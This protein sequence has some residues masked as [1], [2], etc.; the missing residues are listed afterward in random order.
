M[1]RTRLVLGLTTIVALIVAMPAF[2]G[3]D[4]IGAAGKALGIAKKADK[5]SKVAKRNSRLALEKAGPGP[6]GPIG[7]EGP[8]GPAG[9][10]GQVGPQGPGGLTGLELV[11]NSSVHN[12]DSAKHV[13]VDCPPGKVAVGGG[14]DIDGGKSGGFPDVES[15]V[16]LDR[17]S[18][19]PSFETFQASA[20]ETDLVAH[21]WHLDVY[22]SCADGAA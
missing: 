2:G 6:Q 16:V 5:R 19:T 4:V 13:S 8:Q 9:A 22:A 14:A 12:S 10:D 20:Y 21:H 3:P 1:K 18:P 11:T 17:I 7:P 15:H